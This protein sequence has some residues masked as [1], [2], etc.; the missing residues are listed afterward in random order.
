MD[1]GIGYITRCRCLTHRGKK[2]QGS[3]T[4]EDTELSGIA[5]LYHGNGTNQSAPGYTM[6]STSTKLL[7]YC[8]KATE[9][10]SEQ[11]T[12]SQRS[13]WK[14][15]QSRGGTLT[16]DF[17]QVCWPSTGQCTLFT[18]ASHDAFTSLDPV[19]AS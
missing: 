2:A 12:E 18:S 14:S 16:K 8:T 19:P 15:S 6:R 3:V 13:E 10:F 9:L 17:E 5:D 4:R 11:R 7:L 1:V